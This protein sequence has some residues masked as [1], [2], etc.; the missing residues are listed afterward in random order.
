MTSFSIAAL[1]RRF[2]T[3][4]GTGAGTGALTGSI[5]TLLGEAVLLEAVCHYLEADGNTVKL[6]P[7]KPTRDDAHFGAN[8]PKPKVRDL[9]AWILLDEEQ[10]VAVECKSQTASS[11]DSR[12]L[13]VPDEPEQLVAYARGRW[14]QLVAEHIDVDQWTGT[15]K[16]FLPLKPPMELSAEIAEKAMPKLRR[17]LAIWRPISLDG[18]AYISEVA[19]Q[20][21]RNDQYIPAAAEVFSASLYL[22]SLRDHGAARLSLK[23]GL[24]E[25]LLSA[26]EELVAPE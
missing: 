17:I 12:R 21:V 11:I 8:C 23:L 6:L 16:I 22:R 15:N 3:H 7:G 14:A 24:A 25:A 5:S 2:D 26:I 19:S 20:T 18:T 1:L 13:T 4:T 9:D 10:L